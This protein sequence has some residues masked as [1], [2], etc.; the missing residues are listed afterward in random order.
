[1]DASLDFLSPAE[2][3]FHV[4]SQWR[5]TK[6]TSVGECQTLPLESTEAGAQTEKGTDAGVSHEKG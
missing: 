4:P 3:S 6:S 5:S 1:M 2:A